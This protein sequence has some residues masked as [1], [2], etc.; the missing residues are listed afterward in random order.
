M[1]PISVLPL[2][3]SSCG[4]IYRLKLRPLG[5]HHL[6]KSIILLSQQ[7]LRGQGEELGC[8]LLISPLEGQGWDCSQ[9]FEGGCVAS[10]H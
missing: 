2:R 6:V 7:S 1:I 10:E 4:C 5:F 8:V 3:N 9:N